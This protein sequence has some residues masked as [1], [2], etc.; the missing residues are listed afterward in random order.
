ML[1][2]QARNAVARGRGGSPAADD[3]D[4]G[5][6]TRPIRAAGT[7]LFAKEKR[8]AAREIITTIRDWVS[9][10]TMRPAEWKADRPGRRRPSVRDVMGRPRIPARQP[11]YRAVERPRDDEGGAPPESN[12]AFR[13]SDP[14]AR[15]R[16]PG[17]DDVPV[18]PE[19]AGRICRYLDEPDHRGRAWDGWKRPRYR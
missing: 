1:S 15:P 16:S 13:H 2:F 9:P 8:R 19:S 3:G 7:F 14:R 5:A 17:D 10:K 12:C 6:S 18:R 11:R 4:V